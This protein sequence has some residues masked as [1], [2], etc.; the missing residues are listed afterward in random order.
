MK[1]PPP[2]G[3]R[4]RY[5]YHGCK[6]PACRGANAEYQ[7]DRKTHCWPGFVSAGAVAAHLQSLGDQG[8]GTRAV[9]DACDV[10]RLTISR[11]R[12]GRR[13]RI[14]S[15]IAERI[16]RVD[17]GAR[18]DS[19]LVSPRQTRQ[20]IAELVNSGYSRLWIARQLGYKGSGLPFLYLRRI[21][22]LNASRVE[23]LYRLIQAGKVSR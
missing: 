18:A 19:A 8:I 21:T 4:S 10:D 15:R 1:P 7:R 16:L 13:A 17:A 5:F 2:H 23:R 22:A 20:L 9:A 11:I 12:S 14:Q 6:C 3:T